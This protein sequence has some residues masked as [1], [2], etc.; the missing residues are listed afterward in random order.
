M[1]AMVPRDRI[2]F[3]WPLV[4]PFLKKAVARTK[5]RFS[6]EDIFIDLLKGHQTLWIGFEEDEARTI[7]WCGTISI[8]AYPGARVACLQYLGGTDFFE[9]SE[10][11]FQLFKEYAREQ[12][13]DRFEMFGRRGFEKEAQR[14]GGKVLC[15]HY[16]F[17]LLDGEE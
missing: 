14:L 13:C 16:D 17:P 2:Q 7:K 6:T 8:Y 3:E 4:E 9:W 10:A 15:M 11:G 5:G 1:I 12:G